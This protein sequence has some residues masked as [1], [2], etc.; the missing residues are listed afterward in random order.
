M[1]KRQAGAEYEARA[2][3]WL[4]QQGLCILERNFYCRQ[5]E[6]DLVAEDGAYLVFVEVKYRR[7]NRAGHLFFLY[8]PFFPRLRHGF[9]L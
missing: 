7:D 3:E 5:G 9:T 6:V 2:A 4:E 8:F 1:N